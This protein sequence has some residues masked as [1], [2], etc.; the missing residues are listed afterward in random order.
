MIK[1]FF[2]LVFLAKLAFVGHL[3]YNYAGFKQFALPTH[4]PPQDGNQYFRNAQGLWIYYNSWKASE[5]KGVVILVHGFGEHSA[6][7]HNFAQN[8]TSNGF[9]VYA[10]DQQGFGK[11]HGERA[12]VE[13]FQNYVDD[14]LQFSH[15]VL[16]DVPTSTPRFLFG[17]SMGGAV[18]IR[19]AQTPP[20]DGGIAWDGV[21]LSGPLIISPLSTP[22]LVFTARTFSHFFPKLGLL[23]LDIEFLSRDPEVVNH[24]GNDPLSYHGRMKL[25]WASQILSTLSRIIEEIPIVNWPFLIVHGSDDKLVD[26]NGSQL[27]YN[28]V[29][30][31]D[32]T[33]S[34]YPGLYHEVLFEPEKNEI[35]TNILGWLN[36]RVQRKENVKS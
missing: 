16:R 33:L 2:A 5:E 7:Y 36:E 4:S 19:T 30:S 27:F 32:K 8:L 24:V 31:T 1:G 3:A 17:H 25:N 15:L 9:S 13:Y 6:R 12:Y 20:S 34:I 22:I 23:H 10:L 14:V 11:S 18:S 28:K 21:V 29:N 26:V 35:I